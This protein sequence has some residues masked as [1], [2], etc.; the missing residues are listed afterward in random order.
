VIELTSMLE[1]TI[2]K[3]RPDFAQL[4]KVL[5]RAGRPDY[6]PFYELFANVEIM[7][8]VLGKI[9]PDRATKVER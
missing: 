5:K 9:V 2:K 4:L 8:S 6:V 7:E 1:T 3:Q